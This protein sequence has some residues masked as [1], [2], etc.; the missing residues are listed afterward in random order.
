[1]DGVRRL[2][3]WITWQ[4]VPVGEMRVARP[5]AEAWTALGFAVFYIFAA[6]VTGLLIRRWPMPILGAGYFTQ[7]FWYLAVFKIGLLLLVPL[8][9]YHC[10]GYRLRD[11]L[12]RWQL[13]RRTAV[14]LVFWYVL[15]LMIN[16]Q[17]FDY[18]AQG[19][20]NFTPSQL[21][22]RISFGFVT[23]LL[24]AGFPEEFVYRGILQTRLETIWGR[25]A[26]ITVTAVLFMAW[27][28]PSRYFMAAGVEG[29]AGNLT[30]VLIGTGLPV[31]VV[32]L[33]FCLFWDRYR[34][35]W[36]LV[37]AHWAIDTLPSISSFLGY[38][39]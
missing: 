16:T 24:M 6:A 21:V 32:G 30:S 36:P 20:H 26:A 29:A 11:L 39:L 18:I 38:T 33:I 9:V 27:H 12:P 28:I 31:F 23:P 8:L 14:S 22:L 17:H 10:V 19:W 15:C 34:S 7:D 37:A 1:M 25:V 5:R 13:T 4:R 35:F 2:W 3:S